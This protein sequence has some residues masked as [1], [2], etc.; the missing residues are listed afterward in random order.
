MW[1]GL[2][3]APL[4]R[5]FMFHLHPQAFLGYVS[6]SFKPQQ[7]KIHQLLTISLQD[8]FLP[9][10]RFSIVLMCLLDNLHIF[11]PWSKPQVL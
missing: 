7:L 11:M 8:F 5:Y 6:S 10:H 9:N 4:N 1:N 3:S 2:Y